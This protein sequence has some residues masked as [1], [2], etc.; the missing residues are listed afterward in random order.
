M[1]LILR[2]WTEL[3]PGGPCPFAFSMPSGGNRLAQPCWGPQPN[4]GA[5]R[6]RREN[7]INVV[8]QGDGPG[9]VIMAGLDSDAELDG[10]AGSG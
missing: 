1:K 7:S 6:L 2:D 10:L 3:C 8:L 4:R 5:G 9:L